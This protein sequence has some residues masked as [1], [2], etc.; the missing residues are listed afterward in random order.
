M[1]EAEEDEERLALEVLVAELCPV[2]VHQPERP[3]DLRGRDADRSCPGTARAE[4]Q[5]GAETHPETGQE[6]RK[7]DKQP[8]Q[9]CARWCV[10][11]RSLVWRSLVWR[12]LVW[13]SLV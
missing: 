10:H 12:S 11:W 9:P 13:R 8:R 2:L 6:S 7:D 3:A 4:I 1:G 5:D